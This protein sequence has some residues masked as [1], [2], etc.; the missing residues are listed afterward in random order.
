MRGKRAKG[1]RRRFKEVFGAE[2]SD[3]KYLPVAGRFIPS[4]DRRVKRA[5]KKARSR[6]IPMTAQA[7]ESWPIRK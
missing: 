1:L 4:E 7:I 5:Y 6:S 3:T 2:P